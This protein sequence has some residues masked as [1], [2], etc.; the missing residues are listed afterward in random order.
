MSD[1]EAKA[2][3]EASKAIQAVARTAQ[4]IMRQT[5]PFV[6][7]VF[8]PVVENAVGIL[9]DRLAYYRLEHF[10]SL[11]NKTQD[12]LE[13]HGVTAPRS[14]PVPVALPLIEAATIEE[15]ERLHDRWAALLATAMNPARPPVKRSYVGIFRGLEATD[16]ALLDLLY[17]MTFE[18]ADPVGA[19]TTGGGFSSEVEN[20]AKRLDVPEEEA[21]LSLFNL[22]R[23]ECVMLLLSVG[24]GQERYQ[25]ARHVTV[26]LTAL[27]K[28]LVEAYRR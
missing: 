17:D 10:F 18:A 2:V 3:Q 19:T 20:Y 1:E 27:G 12:L 9:S 25:R 15:D 7:R 28:A 11:V 16:A 13:R 22:S 6:G 8:G 5:G 24:L 14:V 4:Q 23:L 21:E 26:K